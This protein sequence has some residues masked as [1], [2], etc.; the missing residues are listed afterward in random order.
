MTFIVD[1]AG[2][3][4]PDTRLPEM[5]YETDLGQL[6]LVLLPPGEYHLHHKF[7]VNLFDVNLPYGSH[8]FAINSDNIK[9]TVF[10]SESVAFFPR[11]TEFR[12]HANN[13]LPG[14]SLEVSDALLAD[15]MEAGEVQPDSGLSHQDYMPDGVAAEFARTAI[16]HLAGSHQSNTPTDRLT[17]EALALGIA[18]RGMAQI[19]NPDGD[20]T[21]EIARWS[22]RA[23]PGAIERAIELLETRLCEADLTIAEL[24]RAA[25]MS[26]SHFASVFK[27]ATGQTPYAFILRRRADFARDLIIGTREPLSWIAYEAGFSSQAHMTTVLRNLHGTTPAAMRD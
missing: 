10:P 16:R 25:G 12:L 22:Y 11:S 3:A 18:A 8:G 1:N 26:S 2:K 19:G 14:C 20:I 5:P 24:A 21:A 17:V 6:R 27:S 15:W 13:R 23:R 7:E 4:K 9:D